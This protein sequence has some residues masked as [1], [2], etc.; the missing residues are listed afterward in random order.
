MKLKEKSFVVGIIAVLVVVLIVGFFAVRL[1]L[2][3]EPE[4]TNELVAAKLE[5]AS[6]LTTARLTYNGLLHY[7]EGSVPLINKKAF[8]MV[9]CAEVEAGI[10]LSQVQVDVR[11]DEVLVMVPEPGI[12][13]IYIDPESITF[14]DEQTALFNPN[15]REEAIDAIAEA[16]ADVRERAGI[17]QLIDTAKTQTTLLLENLLQDTIGE[18][19]LAITF[20]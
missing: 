6:E 9:Y 4:I 20:G 16:E 15:D 17:E 7:E 2:P 3:K 8:F 13:D 18:R 5:E 14:Y 1:F 19:T 12:Q 10:D 11:D